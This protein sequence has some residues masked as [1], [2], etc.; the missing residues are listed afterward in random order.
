MELQT[1]VSETKPRISDVKRC[2]NCG[3]TKSVSEFYRRTP[4]GALKSPCKICENGWASAR[5]AKNRDRNLITMRRNRLKKQFGITPEDYDTLLRLQDYKCVI[6]YEPCPTGNRLAVDHDHHDGSLRGL[7]C[8]PCNTHLGKI[9]EAP[10][11][12]ASALV[13]LAAHGK[14]LTPSEWADFAAIYAPII[15]GSAH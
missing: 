15:H 6:C 11:T 7:L 1:T 5:H 14:S 9:K 4:N 12:V 10:A 13:Y 8:L 3:Q 2:P